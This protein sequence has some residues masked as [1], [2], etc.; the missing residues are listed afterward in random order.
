MSNTEG[1]HM[2]WSSM[3]KLDY[4]E[5]TWENMPGLRCSSDPFQEK[6]NR[7]SLSVS[8]NVSHAVG[9]TGAVLSALSVLS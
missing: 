1:S 2:D 5:G 6:A 8:C 4:R 3:G 9:H 7:S